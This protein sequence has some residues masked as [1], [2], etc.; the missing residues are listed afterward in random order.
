LGG[1]FPIAVTCL[2]LLMLAGTAVPFLLLTRL[3]ASH[4]QSR[5]FHRRVE[6]LQEEVQKLA[7]SLAPVPL[8]VDALERRFGILD[9]HLEDVGERVDSCTKSVTPLHDQVARLRDEHAR[10]VNRC[11]TGSASRHGEI[12]VKLEDVGSEAR[13]THAATS[14]QLSAVT[15]RLGDESQRIRMLQTALRTLTNYTRTLPSEFQAIEQLLDLYRAP[16]PLPPVAGWAMDPTA[17][18]WMVNAVAE[19][20]PQLVVE[21]GSGTSTLWLARALQANGSGGRV[22]SLEHDSKYAEKT[23]SML[24]QHGLA[25]FVE[26]RHTPL[27]ETLTPRGAF[28]WYDVQSVDIREIDMLIV[29]GPPESTGKYARYP[30]LPVLGE[31]LSPGAVVIVDDAS[32]KDEQEMIELWLDER[33]DL[34]RLTVIGPKAQALVRRPPAP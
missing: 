22:L 27:V 29:D 5:N 8:A 12:L 32:R 10:A 2:A 31:R 7:E 23:A 15:N 11:E 9:A 26:V 17:L 13:A 4:T 21:L 28:K 3:D 1:N 24:H 19:R 14:E 18:L 20:H 16:V 34:E 25:E 6:A 30:A 33:P